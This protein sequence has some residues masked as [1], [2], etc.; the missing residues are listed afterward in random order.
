MA[1]ERPCQTDTDGSGYHCSGNTTCRRY[2]KG[3]NDGI[4]SFNNI[5]LAL[6]TVF[7][8]LTMEGWTDVYYLANDAK[9]VWLN[10]LYFVPLVMFLRFL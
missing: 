5:G 7:Q 9:G 1:D 6:L 4:T 2:W 10:W 3:P 8:C